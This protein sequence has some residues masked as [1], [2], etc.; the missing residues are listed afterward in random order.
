MSHDC[1][2]ELA[3]APAESSCDAGTRTAFHSSEGD[4]CQYRTV[5]ADVLARRETPLQQRWCRYGRDDHHDY[6]R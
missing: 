6:D 4:T 2:P 1:L 3:S 5:R